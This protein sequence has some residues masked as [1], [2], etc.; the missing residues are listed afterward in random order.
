MCSKCEWIGRI[1]FFSSVGLKKAK[2]KPLYSEKTAKKTKKVNM[3]T[4]TEQS[5]HKKLE[6][7]EI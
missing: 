1:I 2:D 5:S 3:E 4:T 6:N 7:K